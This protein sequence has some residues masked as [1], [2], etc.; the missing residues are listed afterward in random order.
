MMGVR[1]VFIIV[2]GA[3][4]FTAAQ[5]TFE[6][7]Y[8]TAAGECAVGVVAMPDRGFLVVG[9]TES[10]PG[11]G[12]V[13]AVRTDSVGFAV[14][15]RVMAESASETRIHGAGGDGAGEVVAAGDI[16]SGR[17]D[18]DM[19][20]VGLDTAGA[21]RWVY[22]SDLAEFDDIAT[23]VCQSPDGGWLLGGYTLE[24][25][26]YDIAVVKLAVNG[27]PE[28]TRVLS[29]GEADLAYSI[30]PAAQGGYF[31]AGLTYP[32]GS[33]Y[34]DALLVQLDDTGAVVRQR[35]FGGAL[36]DEA[37]A[38]VGLPGGEAVLAGF[39]SSF[40]VGSDCW[41]QR[42]DSTGQGLWYRT[43]G[44]T[45]TDRA[46]GVIAAADTG[47][48]LA[49][50][51]FSDDNA[52]LFLV[53]TDSRGYVRWQRW[54]GGGGY[55]CGRAA[56]LLGDGGFAVAG[57]TWRD[58]S[59][60]SDMYLVRT[61]SLGLVG[62]EE[63]EPAPSVLAEPETHVGGVLVLPFGGAELL[64]AAGRVVARLVSGAN[65]ISRIRPA[66]YFIRPAVAHARGR[67]AIRRVVKVGGVR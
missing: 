49:G 29:T 32:S 38:I 59:V 16:K 10:V 23:C 37:R 18:R 2:V 24:S 4:G 61:D 66:V 36:W 64:D 51:S 28:W 20:A 13:Y 1:A 21:K 26:Q 41:L 17:I 63:V 58:S 33:R 57:Q 34:C 8:G 45:G 40:G 14:W 54:Y 15:A 67:P 35:T 9:S 65:D 53:R 3:A 30:V 19:Y 22:R 7:S 12:A 25:G 27:T 11:F 31:V 44:G 46:Y 47:L 55:D 6:R 56:L 60:G 50:E 42:V 43:Y 48:L 39:S 52:S 5:P 62:I